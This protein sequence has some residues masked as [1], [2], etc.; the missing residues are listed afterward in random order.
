MAHDF[1]NAGDSA[2]TDLLRLQWMPFVMTDIALLHATLL[3]AATLFGSPP[4]PRR[5]TIDLI[6][7]RG[8]AMGA[9]N[10]ALQDQFRSVSDQIIGAVATMAQYEAF[11]GEND[12]ESKAY[13]L[14]MQ[15]LVHLVRNKG[16]LPSLGLNGLLQK[17]LLAIDYHASRSTGIEVF[18]SNTSSALGMG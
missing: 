17:L 13:Q 10:D 15:G 6:Q 3:V 9:I 14:H 12:P 5:H 18:F 1:L 16:G 11:W 4:G 2:T 8:M 7:L